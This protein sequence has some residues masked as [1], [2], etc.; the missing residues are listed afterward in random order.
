MERSQVIWRLANWRV[1]KMPLSRSSA[2][3]THKFNQITQKE[4]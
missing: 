3:G 4:I 1:A 2:Q